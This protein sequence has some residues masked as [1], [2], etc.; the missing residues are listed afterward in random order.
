MDRSRVD[1]LL[2]AEDPPEVIERGVTHEF[3]ARLI[4]KQ[5]LESLTTRQVRSVSARF[6]ITNF[7]TRLLSNTLFLKLLTQSAHSQVYFAKFIHKVS[8]ERPIM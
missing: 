6:Q 8:A 7:A 5:K 2:N 3:L 1:R 4:K